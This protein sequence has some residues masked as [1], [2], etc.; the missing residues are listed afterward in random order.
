MTKLTKKDDSVKKIK[1]DQSFVH[2]KHNI[3]IRQ[4][5]YW[6]LIIKFFNEKIQQ[7]IQ[8]DSNGF[9][10]E[11]RS[12]F[13]NYIGYDQETKA[14]E[15]DIEALR[16][17]SIIL[18]YLKKDGRPEIHGMGF[19]SE[20]KITSNMIGFRLPSFIE[21]VVKGDYQSQK[22]F[23]MLDWGVF[24]SFSGKYEAIIYK[25]CLDYIGIKRT[26][27]FTID[28]FRDYI[29]LKNDEYKQFKRLNEWVIKKS[30]QAIEN[31]E[32]CDVTIK[33]EYIKEGR[34]VVGL[35]FTVNYKKNE[36][37]QLK[38]LEPTTAF[39]STLIPIPIDRQV[40]Y[41][42]IYSEEQIQANIARANEYIEQL[43]A[44]GKAV[45]MGAIYNKAFT[46]N[47][48]EQKLAEKQLQQQEEELRK[49][50]LEKKQK[51]Q[52]EQLRLQNKKQQEENEL[53][54]YFESLH[55]DM[56]VDL[57]TRMLKKIRP[58]KAM[59]DK[60]KA[61]YDEYGTDI[62]KHSIAFQGNLMEEI[63]EF[64]LTE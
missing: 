39:S 57:I 33:V 35:F 8:P 7:G 52:E 59:H 9:Y 31:N 42:E 44:N 56:K 46:E 29:G 32:N 13:M 45:N 27:C 26:P 63:K 11:P 30:L 24:N 50:E 48:G 51:R 41:L 23:L 53:I 34:S 19:I 21:Q 14:L 36:V 4:Y 5:K 16:K 58:V 18:N 12:S 38:Q 49:I 6:Y 60:F 55:E 25:L 2:I 54:E 43:K 17:E 22:M 40:K 20:Y 62:S 10:F 15:A 47:W 61:S 28:E 3:T 37:L 64:K 1:T